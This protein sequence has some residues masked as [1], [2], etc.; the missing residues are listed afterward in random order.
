[1]KTTEEK[2]I[3]IVRSVKEIKYPITTDMSLTDDLFLDSLDMLMVINAIESEF[4]YEVDM[5]E[6][7]KIKT[8]QDIIEILEAE[9]HK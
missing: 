6:V 5:G 4:S 8:V 1:M 7:G 9:I 2:V 3:E